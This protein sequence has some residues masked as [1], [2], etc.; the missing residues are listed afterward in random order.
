LLY[1][2]A[3][4]FRLPHAGEK[5]ELMDLIERA[6]E[7]ANLLSKENK[8][9]STEKHVWNRHQKEDSIV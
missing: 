3:R 9:K 8:E 5:I 7:T 2:V 1:L 6:P 4:R